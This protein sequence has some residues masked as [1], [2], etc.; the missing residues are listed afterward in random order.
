MKTLKTVDEIAEVAM[1]PYH[2]RD[3]GCA[4]L[5]LH[6]LADLAPEWKAEILDRA[7]FQMYYDDALVLCVSKRLFKIDVDRELGL[8]II[9]KFKTIEDNV[10]SLNGRETF[11]PGALS[12]DEEMELFR[13][14][15]E[16][17]KKE[18][19]KLGL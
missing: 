3:I 5:T 4:I 19:E 13:Q 16:S 8:E 2:F 1:S 15:T 12:E 9:K 10:F 18:I 11:E 14:Y 6:A 17:E 7:R